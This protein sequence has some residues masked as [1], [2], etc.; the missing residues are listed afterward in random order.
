MV[1]EMKNWKGHGKQSWYNSRYYHG[2]YLEGSGK[3]MKICQDSQS[4]GQ[5]L[6]P[7]P[8]KYKK[9]VLTT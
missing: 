4:P 2:I 3:T 8:A 6:N 7:G 1:N 9:G 5:D